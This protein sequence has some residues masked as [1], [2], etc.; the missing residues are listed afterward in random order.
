VVEVDGRP[1]LLEKPIR[2]DFAL[3]AC[4]H[5]DYVGNCAYLL[6]AHNFN[7]VMA[8]A[9]TT[10]IAEPEHIVPVGMIPPDA[11]K[12]PGIIVTHILTRRE[13]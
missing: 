6:T 10:V 5:A 3:I 7:P 4:H 12:T 8:L 11:V 2:G 13:A 9:G 1:Y